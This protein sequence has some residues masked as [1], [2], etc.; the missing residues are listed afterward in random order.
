MTR[1]EMLGNSMKA[2]VMLIIYGIAST[3][4]ILPAVWWTIQAK[5]A[6]LL[7]AL[8]LLVAWAVASVIV[9][10]LAAICDPWI[11][12]L[13]QKLKLADTDFNREIV[14]TE[15]RIQARGRRNDGRIV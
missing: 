1:L 2:I 15:R 8:P 9:K 14:E 6:T 11:E 4:I 12:I 7:E 3:L 10:V 13:L 5:P